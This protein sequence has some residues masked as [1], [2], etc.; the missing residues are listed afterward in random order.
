[1]KVDVTK[2]DGYDDMSAEDKL[3]AV[4]EYDIDVPEPDYSGYVKK[5]VFDKTASE[6]AAKKKEL[7]ATLSDE[8]R[9]KLEREQETQE[10][11][12]NYEKLLRES[13]ISKATAKF[14]ALGYEDK[15]AAETAEAFVDGDNDKVF[16]NQKKA[17]TAFEKKIRA[18]V[19][20][21]TPTPLGGN[22]E[23][24]VMTKKEFRKMG[25]LERHDWAVGH[26]DEYKA[27]YTSDGG[28]D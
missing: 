11:K 24:K 9:A 5:E 10:L 17:Q 1:M 27:L 14:L 28:Q 8:E 7:K 4:L 2:I 22:G 15:L 6:L 12:Q 21:K 18:D 26:P 16:E 19:L 25:D 3:K 20:K 13:N 23:D